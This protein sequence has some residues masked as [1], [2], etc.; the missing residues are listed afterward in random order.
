MKIITIPILNNKPDYKWMDISKTAV[1][2]MLEIS[3]VTM[4][5]QT[6][7]ILKVNDQEQDLRIFMETKT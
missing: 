2:N 7:I 6:P 4:E 3:F 5:N 1:E